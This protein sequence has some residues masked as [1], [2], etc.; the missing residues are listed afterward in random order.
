L[1]KAVAARDGEVPT[2]AT[3]LES[4][5]V[6]PI[7]NSERVTDMAVMEVEI[8]GMAR[9]VSAMILLMGIAGLGD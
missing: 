8:A 4:R 7:S 5:P 1:P 9:P 6:S 2:P 3:P